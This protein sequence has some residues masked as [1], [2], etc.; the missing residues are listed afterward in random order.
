MRPGFYGCAVHGKDGTRTWWFRSD[1]SEATVEEAG[2]EII[3]I[4]LPA[5]TASND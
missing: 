3:A 5:D 1:A 2:A 4:K